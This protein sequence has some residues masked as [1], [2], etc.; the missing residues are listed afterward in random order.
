R[1]SLFHLV[2]AIRKKRRGICEV[3]NPE[4]A[5]GSAIRKAPNTNIQAPENVQM[6]ITKRSPCKHAHEAWRLGI[7]ASMELGCWRLV[8]RGIPCHFG[9]FLFHICSTRVAGVSARFT[10]FHLV[11]LKPK[12]FFHREGSFWQSGTKR[13]APSHNCHNSDMV[14]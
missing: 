10:L 14:L 9:A 11:S 6:P 8:L 13:A 2:S 12:N 3:R 7:G 4:L 1:F 5:T